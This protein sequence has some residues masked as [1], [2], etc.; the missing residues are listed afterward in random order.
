VNARD[1]MPDGGRL[2]LETMNQDMEESEA[3]RQ[4]HLPEGQYVVLTVTDTGSGLAPLARQHLFEPY[5]TTKRAKGAGLG[6]STVYGFVRQ[7]GGNV[8]VHSTPSGGTAV[9]IYLPRYT[10]EA[11]AVER[12]AR[13]LYLVRGAGR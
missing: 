6:L 8:V 11:E 5:F 13:G 1:A 2:T 9:R 3:K 12:A 10:A 7:S 4:A